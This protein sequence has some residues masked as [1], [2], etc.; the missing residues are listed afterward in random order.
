MTYQEVAAMVASFGLPYAYYQFVQDG[1][2]TGQKPVSP[3]FCC[4]YYT[5]SDDLYADNSNYQAIRPLTIELYTDNKDFALEEKVEAALNAHEMP[6]Y[7]EET[8][9]EAERLYMVSYETE[10]AITN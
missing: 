4:Y 7:K 2:Q 1:T 5:R 10:A 6:Y 3:P 8:Y 9:I